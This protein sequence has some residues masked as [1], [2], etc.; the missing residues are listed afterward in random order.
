M[1]GRHDVATAECYSTDRKVE[2]LWRHPCET[3]RSATGKIVL[4]T[5]QA[6]RVPTRGFCSKGHFSRRVLADVARVSQHCVSLTVSTILLWKLPGGWRV[7]PLAM[8][9]QFCNRRGTFQASARL[10]LSATGGGFVGRGR[11]GQG[12]SLTLLQAG[13]TATK[14][15]ESTAHGERARGSAFVRSGSGGQQPVLPRATVKSFNT[16]QPL[17]EDDYSRPKR[18]LGGG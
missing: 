3:C 5:E 10:F 13:P 7:Q 8:L 18:T 1:P 12:C 6:P 15:D 9:R 2:H 17:F 11:H 14:G 4:Q 16:V